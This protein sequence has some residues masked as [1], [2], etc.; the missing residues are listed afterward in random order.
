MHFSERIPVVKRC[1]SVF[2]P[3]PFIHQLHA[4]Q[5]S[6]VGGDQNTR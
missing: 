1:V 5:G 3:V 2:A 6:V 4:V